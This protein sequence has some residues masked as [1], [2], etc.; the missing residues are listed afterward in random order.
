MLGFG[1]GDLLLSLLHFQRVEKLAPPLSPPTSKIVTKEMAAHSSVLAC[2]I[3]WTEEP[4]GL[5]SMGRRRLG[6]D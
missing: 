6:H 1:L 4:G 5:Q 2:I 3:P